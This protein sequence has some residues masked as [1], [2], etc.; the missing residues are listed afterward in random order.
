MSR[1]WHHR[2]KRTES[3]YYYESLVFKNE[4]INPD[5]NIHNVIAI[6]LQELKV[7]TISEYLKFVDE[8]IQLSTLIWKSSPPTQK[9]I[10]RF[11]Y[12][13]YSFSFNIISEKSMRK[14][15]LPA[16]IQIL[17]KQLYEFKN[18]FVYYIS[19]ITNRIKQI[20]DNIEIV[21]YSKLKNSIR[22]FQPRKNN[23]IADGDDLKYYEKWSYIVALRN[24]FQLH[25]TNLFDWCNNTKELKQQLI[26]HFNL[27][28][29]T[30][31]EG[32][33]MYIDKYNEIK[34]LI[35]TSNYVIESNKINHKNSISLNRFE[36]SFINVKFPDIVNNYLETVNVKKAVRLRYN[37]GQR[38]KS[39]N[40]NSLLLTKSKRIGNE[41]KANKRKRRLL[42]K[43]GINQ[44]KDN[45]KQ[46]SSKYSKKSKQITY[47]KVIQMKGKITNSPKLQFKLLGFRHDPKTHQ[48]FDYRYK[49]HTKQY[50]KIKDLNFQ[51]NVYLN[52]INYIHQ[53][54]NYNK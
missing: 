27:E 9:F 16:K 44:I 19:L 7:V 20:R 48:L 5:Y 38:Q 33:Q 41:I 52:E 23:S 3:L 53:S 18:Q 6:L 4:N 28:N 43:T 8:V 1:T 49:K 12:T 17:I 26:K 36:V 47:H 54:I 15:N 13:E 22:L 40:L 39:F 29:D 2:L 32:I 50:Y 31:N 46:Y 24:D 11:Y 45:G 51:K 34:S 25:D 21:H 30:E 37:Y 10:G 42:K 14:L 35:E